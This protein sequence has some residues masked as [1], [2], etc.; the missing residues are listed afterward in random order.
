ML[1]SDDRSAFAL[2]LRVNIGKQ[3]ADGKRLDAFACQARRSISNFRRGNRLQ[4]VALGIK[5]AAYLPDAARRDKKHRRKRLR[6]R[7]VKVGP[8]LTCVRERVAKAARGDEPDARA[9]PIEQHVHRAGGADPDLLNGG[10]LR[11]PVYASLIQR[12]ED[13]LARG[14]SASLDLARFNFAATLQSEIDEA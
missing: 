6:H 8:V 5:P 1:L 3:Q 14:T 11:R 12:I 9:L 13:R 4:N 10:Q 7:I 2:V